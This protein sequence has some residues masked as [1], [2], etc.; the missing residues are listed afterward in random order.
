MVLTRE[1]RYPHVRLYEGGWT[2]YAAEEG[3]EVER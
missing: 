1:L 2:E 3:V